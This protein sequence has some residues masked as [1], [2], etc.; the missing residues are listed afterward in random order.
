V[1]AAR[2]SGSPPVF[3][4]YSLHCRE[5]GVPFLGTSYLLGILLPAAIGAIIGPRLLRW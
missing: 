1:C 3:V 2:R 4:V 5:M